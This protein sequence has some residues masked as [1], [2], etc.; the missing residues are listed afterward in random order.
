MVGGAASGDGPRRRT[1]QF[2]AMERGFEM[3]KARR[4]ADGF[5]LVELLVV[6]TIIGIL[7]GLLLPA[8]QKARESA[9]RISC[10]NNLKQI[11]DGL[12]QYMEAHRECLPVGCPGDARHGLFT[13]LLP[14]ID[15]AS[16]YRDEQEGNWPEPKL[17]LDSSHRN[18]HQ[19]PH[20]YTELEIYICPSWPYDHVYPSNANLPEDEMKGAIT[21]YQGVAGSFRG[22]GPTEDEPFTDSRR[23]PIPKNG[24]FGWDIIKRDRD[25]KDGLS[26]TLCVGEFAHLDRNPSSPY[27]EPP[28]NVRAWIL[29][30]TVTEDERGSFAFKVVMHQPNAKVDRVPASGS[31]APFNWL[32]MSSFHHGGINFLLGDGSVTF[33]LESIDLTLYKQ[34]ATCNGREPAQ[35]P[36]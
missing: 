11:G 31:G 3:R 22:T 27:S 32:P 5:T 8:V 4:R 28:G 18:T 19:E 7:I 35:V 23:G 6:I 17:D 34:L 15:Q 21:S 9:R 30:S 24:L 36:D 10:T 14:F 13:A 16:M 33:L 20:R 1:G 29:G 26:N 12:H 25:V 2:P